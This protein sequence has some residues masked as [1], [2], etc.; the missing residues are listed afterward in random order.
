MSAGDNGD[1]QPADEEPADDQSFDD[2]IATAND[3]IDSLDDPDVTPD[4]FMS[5]IEAI[6][7]ALTQADTEAHLD[8]LDAAVDQTETH[9][10][11]ADLPEPE[12]ED[13]PD[14]HDEIED[15][16][17]DITADIEDHRG[18]YAE[19]ATNTIEDAID[20]IT[21]T[22]WTDTGKPEVLD[23][24]TQFIARITDVLSGDLDHPDSFDEIPL[25]L[26]AVIDHILDQDLDPDNDPDTISTLLDITDELTTGLDDAEEWDD[27]STKEQLD[28]EGFYDVLDHRKDFPPEL[29]ALKVWE[30]RARTDQILLALDTLD[31]DFMEEHCLNALKRLGDDDALEPMLQRAQ[32]RDHDAIEIIGKIGNP[33]ATDQIISHAEPNGDIELQRTTIKALGEIGDTSA[34]QTIAN[35]L[36]HDDARVRA[37]AARALGLIGDPR[38]IA[39]LADRLADDEAVKVRGNA[40]W[41]L[42]QIRT[43]PALE[44]LTDYLDDDHVLVKK[45]ARQARTHLNAPAP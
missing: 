44:I 18:P 32:R 12:D 1:D 4:D 5:V 2:L 37:V 36:L 30:Q 21:E 26:E 10:E 8:A 34:T 13:D 16:L 42:R 33:E 9:L 24:I 23:T 14:P 11:A 41:A 27:L 31:I 39:P 25:T 45:E 15:T 6:E 38:A 19:D 29:H 40:A 28:Y 43:E 22:R 17:E 3:T 35:Q 20:T 7:T